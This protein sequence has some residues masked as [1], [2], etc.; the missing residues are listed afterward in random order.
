M[1]EEPS[2]PNVSIPSHDEQRDKKKRYTV[3]VSLYTCLL[4][5]KAKCTK[6]KWIIVL[7]CSCC[8]FLQ[9]YK[10]IVSV[11]PQEWFV[12]RRYAEFDKLYNTVSWGTR[13]FLFHNKLKIIILFMVRQLHNSLLV[14]LSFITAKKTVSIYE[15]ENP[16]KENI[17]GQ[18]WPRLV[19]SV[20]HHTYRT[21]LIHV[22]SF[23]F[24]SASIQ[25]TFSG[26][27]ELVYTS[28]LSGSS[29]ILRFATSKWIHIHC[30]LHVFFTDLMRN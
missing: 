3:C 18:F 27:E 22:Y 15:F 14:F 17:R 7:Y 28:S 10:V 8:F 26:K 13:W 9:V 12:L 19:F 16:S 29:H 6:A 1:E 20:R 23:I 25:Q 11:G 4:C 5:S 24:S 21:S 2:L 30:S